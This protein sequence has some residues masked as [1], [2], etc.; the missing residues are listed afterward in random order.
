MTSVSIVFQ[1]IAAGRKSL[2]MLQLKL[3]ALL[4]L[5]SVSF[6]FTAEA[7]E[8]ILPDSIAPQLALTIPTTTNSLSISEPTKSARDSSSNEGLIRNS[9]TTHSAKRLPS[10]KPFRT[11]AVSV[12]GSTLGAG[13]ELATPL[14]RCFNIR[15]GISYL[16]FAYP[17]GIDGVNYN[18]SL[19]FKSSQ[20]TLDWFPTGHTFHISPG[21]LYSRNTVSSVAT[22]PAGKN[23]TLGDQSFLNSVDDPV[24]GTM[25]VIY[26]HNLSPMLLLGFGNT[27]PRD[28]HHLTVPV[29]FGV[30]YTGAATIDVNLS[31]TACT[32]EGCVSFMKNPE[33]QTSLRQEIQIL[34][35]DLKKVP[36]YPIVS[37]GVAYHF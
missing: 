18:A 19:H 23:F 12:K 8:Q 28:N 17:F 27:L 24:H 31:G 11:V 29:E 30:A 14:L 16:T 10:Q 4:F 32:S 33:A 21:V 22:V 5:L 7:Q 20:T 1:I 26:P 3:I 37:I 34:N 35:E 2:D 36:V 6:G 13:I 15:S 9:L 25:S